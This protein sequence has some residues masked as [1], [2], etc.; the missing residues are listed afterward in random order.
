MPIS[1]VSIGLGIS[2]YS[3]INPVGVLNLACGTLFMCFGALNCTKN[4]PFPIL[5]T[6]FILLIKQLCPLE[7][8]PVYNCDLVFLTIYCVTICIFWCCRKTN[9][10]YFLY[11]QARLC[12]WVPKRTRVGAL[13]II[14]E[15]KQQSCWTILGARKEAEC[16]SFC[17][18][19]SQ[20]TGSFVLRRKLLYS[21]AH[22]TRIRRLSL[23]S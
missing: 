13:C 15:A 12:I 2:Y 9:H 20:T 6:A 17:P 16:L 5:F 21:F 7:K 11:W 3:G 8:S 18:F 19:P 23:Q 4:C 1:E 14:F 10:I 22:W